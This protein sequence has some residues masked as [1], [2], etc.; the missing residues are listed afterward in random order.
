MTKI[1]PTTG[2]NDAIR[3]VAGGDTGA[4]SVIAM[5]NRERPQNIMSYL[6]SL[7]EKGVYGKAIYDMFYD[8][9]HGNLEKFV[10]ALSK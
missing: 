3:R 2:L 6:K 7:D 4:A 1:L 5:L 10:S 8:T 9:C